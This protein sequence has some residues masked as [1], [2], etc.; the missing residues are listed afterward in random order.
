MNGGTGMDNVNI[1]RSGFYALDFAL[2]DTQGNI[3][4]L[5]N[6]LNGHFT[7]LCFFPDGEN[8]KV[9]GYLKDLNQGL[10]PNAVGMP[11]KLVG[12][13][14]KRGDRLR[15]L[16]E[17]LKLN[18]PLLSDSKLVVASK[19]HVW[20]RNS[21]RPSVYFSVFIVDDYAVIRHRVS[22]V[23]GLSKYVP[24]EL[25]MTISKLI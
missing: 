9:N 12:I 2:P 22:E 8:E 23:P 5:R 17:K 25:R 3:F 14:P 7:A 16:K 18:F 6:D 15:D 19:Y 21:P 11:T 4:R 1:I 13:C 24:D 10:P 20:D